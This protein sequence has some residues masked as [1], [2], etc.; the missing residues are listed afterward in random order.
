MG[1]KI[2]VMVDLDLP[3]ACGLRMGS[4]GGGWFL[5]DWSSGVFQALQTAYIRLV[6]T[7]FYKLQGGIITSNRFVEGVRRI[8]E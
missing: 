4:W 5:L 2:V 6:C 8:G 1:V 7:Q 3:A